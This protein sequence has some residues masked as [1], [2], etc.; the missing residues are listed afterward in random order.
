[1]VRR[2]QRG[3]HGTDIYP[4]EPREPKLASV[5]LST[6]RPWETTTFPDS[7]ILKTTHISWKHSMCQTPNKPYLIESYSNPIRN[8]LRIYLILL[9]LKFSPSKKKI[10][11]GK[12]W[13]VFYNV[14][15]SKNIPFIFE[16]VHWPWILS[17]YCLLWF[18]RIKWNFFRFLFLFF[19]NF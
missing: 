6:P 5:S 14:P 19:F 15:Y 2:V 13:I 18:P 7:S 8:L 4:S 10:C 12:N 3:A 17:L 11:D 1:M 9:V 16:I